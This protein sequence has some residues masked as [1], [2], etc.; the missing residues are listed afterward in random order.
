MKIFP[1]SNFSQISSVSHP[2]F[3]Y[4]ENRFH[5]WIKRASKDHKEMY[6]GEP[7]FGGGCFEQK[8]AIRDAISNALDEANETGKPVNLIGFD[9]EC[10]FE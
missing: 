2:V 3:K 5:S 8:G 1:N 4:V 10:A 7:E 6:Y 9:L